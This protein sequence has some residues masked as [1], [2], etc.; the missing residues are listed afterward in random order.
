MT[1]LVECLSYFI[2]L[3]EGSIPLNIFFL[4]VHPYSRNSIFSTAKQNSYKRNSSMIM[5]YIGQEKVVGIGIK[6]KSHKLYK[7]GPSSV[8]LSIYTR[9]V[10]NNTE[11]TLVFGIDHI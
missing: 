9:K 11:E 10:H 2:Y 8:S 5:G 7:T 6:A 1:H 3:E 4:M